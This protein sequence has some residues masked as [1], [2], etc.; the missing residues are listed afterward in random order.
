MQV[1][2]KMGHLDKSPQNALIAKAVEICENEGIPYLT[3]ANYVYERS[4]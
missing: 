2:S 1:L 4:G 3:Y